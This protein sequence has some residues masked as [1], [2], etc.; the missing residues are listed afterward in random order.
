MLK[1]LGIEVPQDGITINPNDA[2]L[3]TQFLRMLGKRMDIDA[4]PADEVTEL[5]IGMEGAL[6]K[7]GTSWTS[8]N[9][10]KLRASLR[11]IQRKDFGMKDA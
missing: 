10:D 2:Y 5:G 7:S 6:G 8:D 9:L 11:I 3:Y 4:I 1:L